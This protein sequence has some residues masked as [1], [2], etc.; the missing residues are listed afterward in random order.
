MLTTSSMTS[1]FGTRPPNRCFVLVLARLQSLAVWMDSSRLIA[2]W[3][4]V[5][6]A[7][8]VAPA[9]ALAEAGVVLEP[10]QAHVL[11]LI[12][13][14]LAHTRES[15]ELFTRDGKPLRTGDV[16]ALPPLAELLG[17]IG[18]GELTSFSDADLTQALV[19]LCVGHNPMTAADLQQYA[20]ISRDPL[21]TDLNTETSAA[22][23]FTNS[24]PSFGGAIVSEAL[25]ALAAGGEGL[26]ALRGQ[27]SGPRRR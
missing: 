27:C 14:V 21:R 13:P 17:R 8:V 2:R 1:S 7:D 22:R 23:L 5:P 16:F 3:G 4:A 10:A 15:W 19:D 6:L 9:I 26:A 12:E 11:E 20:V 18:S 25:V 24:A